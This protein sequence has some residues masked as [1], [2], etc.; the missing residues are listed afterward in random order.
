[1]KINFLAKKKLRYISVSVLT[2]PLGQ[3]LLFLFAEIINL[4]AFTSNVLAV[5][6][7]TIPNYLLNR[8]W[9][10]KIKNPHSFRHEILPY[11]S[12]AFLGLIIST[13][14]VVIADSIW[15]IWIAL[16]IANAIA[17]ALLWVAKYFILEM[18]IFSETKQKDGN[19][20]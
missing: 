1:M 8:F 18:Y 20:N 16:N 11:W 2:A 7:A 14:F 19:Q 3:V 15:S 12:I 13:I 9:V 17:Y 10:W 6:I 5:L 4:S